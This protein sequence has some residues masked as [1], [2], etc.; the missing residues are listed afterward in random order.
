V[1]AEGKKSTVDMKS[2][3]ADKTALGTRQTADAI[4][5]TTR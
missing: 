1:I 4:I 3:R 2:R 5:A